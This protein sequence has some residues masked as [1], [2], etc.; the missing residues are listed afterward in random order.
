MISKDVRK[1][2]KT[3]RRYQYEGTLDLP[4]QG[5]DVFLT[6]ISQES[7]VTTSVGDS[8]VSDVT[9]SSEGIIIDE[10]TSIENIPAMVIESDASTVTVDCLVDF[11]MKQFEKRQFNT[12]YFLG[13]VSTEVGSLILIRIFSKPG[14]IRFKFTEGKGLVSIDYFKPSESEK[15]FESLKQSNDRLTKK[16]RF[17]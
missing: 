7:L 6:E 4:F 14:E 17:K 5:G 8:E 16:L 11:E 10:W 12:S 9:I 3:G 1:T 15:I 13:K 2:T